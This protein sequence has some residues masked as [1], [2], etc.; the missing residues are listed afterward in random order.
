MEYQVI[1]ERMREEP[2]NQWSKRL[3]LHRL[4][5]DPPPDFKRRVVIAWYHVSTRG[6]MPGIRPRGSAF[7][8][9]VG[10]LDRLVD[11]ERARQIRERIEGRGATDA[12]TI[13]PKPDPDAY[14]PL[15]E[16]EGETPAP[17]RPS[18]PGGRRTSGRPPWRRSTF[19]E[20]YQEA[21]DATPEPQTDTTVAANFRGLGK[22]GTLG[23]EPD[24]LARL[25]RKAESG[26]MPE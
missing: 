4:A 13:D 23:I 9:H 5:G 25:R 7:A 19:A 26:D 16:I 10:V 8:P 11:A 3:P 21:V 20:R 22:D 12:A 24:S 14:L 2:D 1:V 6:E 18:V 17:G 15:G